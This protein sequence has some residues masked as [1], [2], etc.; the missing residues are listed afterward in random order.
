MNP[1]SLACSSTTGDPKNIVEE[2][3]KFFDM[4]HVIDVERVELDA[5]QMKSESRTWFD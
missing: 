3:Q 4:M 1:P 5:Y 2:L